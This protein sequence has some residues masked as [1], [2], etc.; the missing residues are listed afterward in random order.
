MPQ[1]DRTYDICPSSSG[2]ERGAAAVAAAPVRIT[3]T[4]A[5]LSSL[6]RTVRASM[7]ARSVLSLR[8][9]ASALCWSSLNVALSYACVEHLG[10]IAGMGGPIART[11]G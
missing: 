9:S 1:G 10:H 5:L 2:L 4:M 3:V 11:G 6:S 7:A 8:N